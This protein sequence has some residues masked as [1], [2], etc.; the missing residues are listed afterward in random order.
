M[1]S[2]CI[3][4]CILDEEHGLCRGCHRTLDE[5][6]NWGLLPA[7]E[8]QRIMAALAERREQYEQAQQEH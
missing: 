6:G 4:I 5:I 2:P 7:P 8:R 1:E 3:N